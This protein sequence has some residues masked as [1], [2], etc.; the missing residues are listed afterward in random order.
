MNFKNSSS[1]VQ[2]QI[3]QMLRLY[4]KFSKIYV[5]NT[6]IFFITF[7]EHVKYLRQI[8]RLFQQK[9]VNLTFI[10]SFLN[11]LFIILLNQRIDNLNLSI[12]KE[13]V[14]IITFL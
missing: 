2:R 4:R 5:N 10:K 7:D 9:C 8:F 12:S 14:I 1:Y 13:K 3:D 6:I 11:Y